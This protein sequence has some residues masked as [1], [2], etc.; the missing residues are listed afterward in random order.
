VDCSAGGTVK[1]TGDCEAECTKPDGALFC[2]GKWVDQNGNLDEC[3]NAL[4]T[5]LSAH[6]TADARGSA[7][8]SN[9]SCTAEGEA[10]ASSKCSAA[11]VGVVGTSTGFGFLGA[12]IALA[13][14]RRRRRA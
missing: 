9:G 12:V 14:G 4:E 11:P 3:I 10:S 6:I 1:C 8:C 2:D 13:V 5:Y 7:E